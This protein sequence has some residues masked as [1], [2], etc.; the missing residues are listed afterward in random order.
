MIEE[1]LDTVMSQRDVSLQIQSSLL[2]DLLPIHNSLFDF[3]LF[4]LSSDVLQ[5]C[6]VRYCDILVNSVMSSSVLE[7]SLKLHNLSPSIKSLNL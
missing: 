1:F 4:R 6:A 5:F 2:H 7:K 3:S